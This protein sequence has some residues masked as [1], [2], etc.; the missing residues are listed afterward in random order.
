MSLL[1]DTCDIQPV[2]KDEEETMREFAIPKSQSCP[3]LFMAD[4][5]DEE[6]GRTKARERA[7][8]ESMKAKRQRF[9]S[10]M[11]LNRGA[12]YKSDGD[13]THIDKEKTFAFETQ[14][15]G[16]VGPGDLLAK[17]VSALGGFRLDDDEEQRHA[18]IHSSVKGFHGFSDSQILASEQNYQSDWSITAS[19][20]SNGTTPQRSRRGT[21]EVRI[22][23]E[24][25]AKVCRTN[26]TQ[27]LIKQRIFFLSYDSHFCL[28][29]FTRV[30]FK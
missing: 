25:S 29:S 16:T 26:L 18:S 10:S 19:D 4:D 22:P 11:T 21:S 2:Y 7:L 8:S 27:H 15:R 24:E 13:L 14:R 12:M 5:D 3:S 20:R 17:V 9:A 28:F 6:E 1:L 30:I 23:I